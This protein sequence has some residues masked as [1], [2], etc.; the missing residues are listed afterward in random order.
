LVLGSIPETP[1]VVN[2]AL[3]EALTTAVWSRNARRLR[4]GEVRFQCPE[5]EQHARGDADPSARWSEVRAVWRCDACGASGGACDLAARLGV[6]VPTETTYVIRDVTGADV[7]QHVR[8]DLPGGGKRMR[9]SRG[10]RFDLG[11]LSVTKLPLY[12]SET[13]AALTPGSR[14][15]LCEGEKAATALAARGIAAVATVTGASAVPAD[16]VLAMLRGFVVVLWPDAD[17]PGR[18]HMCRIA[19][20][21]RRLGITCLAVDPWGDTDTGADA[22]DFDGDDAALRALL[23]TAREPDL[24]TVGVLVAD[25]TPERVEWLW[26]GR[27]PRGKL[28]I[29]EGRPDEGKT[30]LALDLAARVSTGAAMPFETDTRPPAGVVVLS[31]EDGLADTIRPRLEAAGANLHRIVAAKPEELP[32]L[33]A[34]G[35]EYIVALIERVDAQ[36]VVIDP[37]MAFI[38]D[39][40]DTHRDH[41]SRRL[42]R[43]LSG[44]AEATGATVLV[45]RH[46]HKGVAL[47]AKDAG[48]G[49]I[50][51]TAAARVV[52]LAGDDPED[53]TQKVLARVKGNLSAPFPALAYRLVADGFTVRVEW[54]RETDHL[55][56]QLLALPAAPEDR[57]ALGEAKDVILDLLANGPVAADLAIKQLKA[58]GIAKRTW[59]RA[60]TILRVCSRKEAFSGAWSWHPPDDRVKGTKDATSDK[61]QNDGGLR[62]VGGLRDGPEHEE[63]QNIEERQESVPGETRRAWRSSDGVDPCLETA[64]E[65]PEPSPPPRRVRIRL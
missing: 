31:A 34:A 28:V 37:L 19:R 18:E 36:L 3:V 55:A 47:N 38:P 23:D 40:L 4:G 2:A 46:V 51:F 1:A 12:R 27:L 48:G 11:G 49:S 65:P 57:S 15:V 30:T 35:I 39:Q 13:L 22:A 58:R 53:D 6:T 8:T 54:L 16:E 44:L 52:L 25:V 43:K 61:G 41:H 9:W 64:P 42:L 60:K 20:R 63:R 24:G 5:S 7:A 14:V 62:D 10:G 33:D 21:L 50:G 17:P 29:L 59:E 56:E 26:Y 32:T 45:L